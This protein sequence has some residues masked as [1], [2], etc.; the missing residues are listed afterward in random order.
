MTKKR[1]TNSNGRKNK[2]HDTVVIKFTRDEV[3]SVIDLF[4]NLVH[5]VFERMCD[6]TDIDAYQ[7]RADCAHDLV[8]LTSLVSCP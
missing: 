7:V 3:E 8:G 1:T 5:T 6:A 2:K 4:A